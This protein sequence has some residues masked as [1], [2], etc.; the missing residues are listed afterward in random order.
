MSD[1]EVELIDYF[2]EVSVCG[3]ADMLH[4][5][6]RNEKYEQAIQKAIKYVKNRGQIARV[7]DIGTGTGLLSM[8]AARHGADSII[9]CESFKPMSQC[10]QNTIDLNGFSDRIHVIPKRSTN[11]RVC[12]DGKRVKNFSSL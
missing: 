10:A 1:F 7:L 4:D 5:R 2:A 11:L 6:D 12:Q 8:M 3:F 9:A